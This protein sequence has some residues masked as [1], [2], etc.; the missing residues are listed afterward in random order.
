MAKRHVRRSRLLDRAH[1]V[2]PPHAGV[3]SGRPLEY[4]FDRL[5]AYTFV[6]QVGESTVAIV[7]P[8]YSVVA[9]I[10]KRHLGDAR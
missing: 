2:R 5:E 8:A 10:R 4:G 6:R 7:D 3:G 9:K 1:P